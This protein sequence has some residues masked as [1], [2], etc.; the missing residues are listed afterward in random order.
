MRIAA[1]PVY[2]AFVSAACRAEV[3][4]DDGRPDGS[5]GNAGNAGKGSGG[6]AGRGAGGSAGGGRYG[7]GGSG[8][9]G[10]QDE[11]GPGSG[12][13]PGTNNDDASTVGS[14]GSGAPT[15]EAGLEGSVPGWPPGWPPSGFDAGPDGCTS[16]G[17][18]PTKPVA[19]RCEE[20]GSSRYDALHKSV[21]VEAPYLAPSVGGT[22][23][24]TY[25]LATP[26]GASY[27]SSRGAITM[28]NGWMVID[29][30]RAPGVDTFPIISIAICNITFS[31]VCGGTNRYGDA[32]SDENVGCERMNL[33][34]H[35]DSGVELMTECVP[36]DCRSR[37]ADEALLP[38]P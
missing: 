31:D 26:S 24:L 27:G 23:S 5:A 13:S 33:L 1:W 32:L 4:L 9:S 2:V 37:C 6:V 8:G 15:D 20:F 29:L 22:Y 11:G 14:G 16:V 25:T 17:P 35:A 19:T 28:V 30:S 38:S 36:A 21:V 7:A 3:I 34:P 10:T 12:D 18:A